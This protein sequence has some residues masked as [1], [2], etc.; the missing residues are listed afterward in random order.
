MSETY[1][2]LDIGGTYIKA[3]VVDQQ[4]RI[5][6]RDRMETPASE[7]PEAVAATGAELARRISDGD[8]PR[9][10]GLGAASAGMMNAERTT[11]LFAPNLTG[12]EDVPLAQMLEDKTGLPCTLENDANAAALGEYW[13]GAGR[14]TK[15]MVLLTLGTGIGGG[16]VLEGRPLVGN[17]GMGS[18]LGHMSLEPDGPTCGCGKKG[19]LEALASAPAVVRRMKDMI[20]EGKPTSLSDK[21]DITAKDV[22]EAVCDGDEAAKENFRITA[23]YLGMGISNY[24]YI[25]NPGAVVLSGGMA[26]AGDVLLDPIREEVEKQTLDIFLRNLRICQ[27]E[28]GN[29]AGTVGAARAFLNRRE[30]AD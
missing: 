23:S 18:E 19:C 28:L 13:R 20:A 7:G 6:K 10:S 5:L 16:V 4:G 14:E 30:K 29:D 12:W 26:A 1:I 2:G 9:P 25:F 22:Y 15:V 8:Y 11:V 3:A 27:A 17:N 24:L 21:E